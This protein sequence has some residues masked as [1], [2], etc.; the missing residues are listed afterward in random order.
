MENVDNLKK[1]RFT[2]YTMADLI[3]HIKAIHKLYNKT[4]MYFLAIA[5]VN[6]NFFQYISH[7]IQQLKSPYLYNILYFIVI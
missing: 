1:K 2:P 4:Y 3:S 6:I 5:S 7:H